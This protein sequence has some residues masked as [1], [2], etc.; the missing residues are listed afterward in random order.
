MFT[1]K[2]F[3]LLIPIVVC[4]FSSKGQEALLRK[5]DSYKVSMNRILI[6]DVRITHLLDSVIVCWNSSPLSRTYSY[7][8]M[9]PHVT[10]DDQVVWNVRIE[11]LHDY[12]SFSMLLADNPEFARNSVS[13]GVIQ[14]DTLPFYVGVEKDSDREL[15]EKKV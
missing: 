15:P 5:I 8:T 9:T 6:K 3:V 11:Q 7:A 10:Y 13:Y 12:E 2:R 4:L 1:K 14:Y